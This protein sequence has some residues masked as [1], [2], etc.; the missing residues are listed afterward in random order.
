M[1][2]RRALSLLWEIGTKEKRDAENRKQ[3]TGMRMNQSLVQNCEMRGVV[4]TN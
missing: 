4:Q 3:K 2:R 1:G